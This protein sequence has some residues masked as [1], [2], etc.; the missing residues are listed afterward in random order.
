MTKLIVPFERPL[1]PPSFVGEVT[2]PGNDIKAVKRPVSRMGL[3]PWGEFD[4]V[5]YEGFSKGHKNKLG[6]PI[7]GEQGVAGLQRILGIQATGYWGK[8]THEASLT[9]RVPN[10]LP[11]EGEFIWDQSAINLYNG[12]E[13]LSPAENLV[14]DIFGWWD[15]LVAREPSVHYDQ[16]R[17]INIIYRG[18]RPPKLPLSEDCSGTFISCAWLA[19]AKTPDPWYGYKGYG[20]TDSLVHGGI[21][22]NESQI[23][24]YC[25]THYVAAFYGTAVWDTHHVVAVKDANTIYSH[26]REA[27]PE[28]IRNNLHYHTY[29]LVAIR[30]YPV[31]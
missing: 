25:K 10:G 17:P 7:K 11:H 13:D 19:G 22:I 31:I 26:G 18:E 21:P 20:S 30:A 1:Y 6:K 4:D 2:K 8:P 23:S 27:G 14:K 16:G 29:Q 5:Y 3:W 12:F 9:L 24:A 15:W 28:I